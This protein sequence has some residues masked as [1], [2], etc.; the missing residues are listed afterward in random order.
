MVSELAE[1][2]AYNNQGRDIGWLRTLIA[3]DSIPL[4]EN[5]KRFGGLYKLKEST[6]GSPRDLPTGARIRPAID[7]SIRL[8]DKLLLEL[9]ETSVSTR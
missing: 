8:Q 5:V 3:C 4:Q 9:S 2:G 6:A 1:A 7:E